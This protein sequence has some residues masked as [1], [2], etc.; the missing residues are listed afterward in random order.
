MIIKQIKWE[1]ANTG[2]VKLNTNGSADIAAGTTGG[3]GLIRDDRGSWI[4]GFTRKI[5]KADSFLAETQ[6]L[7]DGLLLCNQLKFN[8]VMV[9]LDA[10]ALVD[11]LKKSFIC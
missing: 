6:A 5:D 11:A 9:E 8:A 10:K 2:W 3:G 4:M 7:H 1:K